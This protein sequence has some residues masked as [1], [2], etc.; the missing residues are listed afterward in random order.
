MRQLPGN[1]E[2]QG[3]RVWRLE[4]SVYTPADTEIP[5]WKCRRKPNRGLRSDQKIS[6]RVN[7]RPAGVCG[8]AR[9]IVYCGSE[10]PARKR[11]PAGRRGGRLDV[12]RIR[13]ICGESKLAATR[14]E[15]FNHRLAVV[16]EIPSKTSANGG[17]VAVA[18]DFLQ[19][20]SA[21]LRR[22]CDGEAWR[23]IVAVRPPIGTTVGPSG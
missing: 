19:P 22:P 23:E 14:I 8:A 15:G 21:W 13:E 18:D 16:V 9:D 4:R 6:S 17:L 7:E 12:G 2:I 1:R 10:R 20:V 11:R 5:R 3:V